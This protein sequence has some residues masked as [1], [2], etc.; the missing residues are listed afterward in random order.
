MICSFAPISVS[1]EQSVLITSP[2]EGAMITSDTEKF[3]ANIVGDCIKAIYYLDDTEIGIADGSGE[4]EI[5]EGI[6]TLGNHTLELIV[7]YDDGNTKSHTVQFEVVRRVFKEFYESFDAFDGTTSQT[8]DLRVTSQSK[9]S[10]IKETGKES[11]EGDVALKLEYKTGAVSTTSLP[12]LQSATLKNYGSGITT[13]EFDIKLNNLDE[14]IGLTDM[15]LWSSVTKLFDNGKIPGTD[16]KYL[17]GWLNIKIVFDYT[18]STASL[19]C[20][21][22]EIISDKPLV[23][24]KSLKSS[25][26]RMSLFQTKERAEGQP[27]AGMTVDNFKYSRD[28]IYTGIDSVT[29][30]KNDTE[31]EL[32]RNTLPLDAEKIKVYFNDELLSKSITDEVIELVVGSN[33]IPLSNVIYNDVEKSI[34][35]DINEKYAGESVAV[36]RILPEAKFKDGTVFGT[37]AE[38]RLETER[39]AVKGATFKVNGSPL[40]SVYQLS[41]GDI[42]SA[43]VDILNNTG[44]EKTFTVVLQTRYENSL[45]QIV[46]KS[47][48]LPSKV[49][50]QSVP[51]SLTPLR[52]AENVYVKLF[53]CDTVASA[54]PCGSSFIIP[55]SSGNAEAGF[56]RE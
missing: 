35:A 45:S 56:H 24:N 55:I 9:A 42:I 26:F 46:A 22:E 1:A 13:V 31:S 30:I 14:T 54:I 49:D 33:K 25:V 39:G 47:V 34:T 2:A 5:P 17:G 12:Y 27:N 8:V 6:L 36:V 23:Y 52:D 51:I 7:I 16:Y 15:C 19:Y 40:K 38:Y 41:T 4:L 20:D 3:T 48:T 10:M 29:C 11:Y 32:Y 44:A 53:V 37:A 43:D 21:G 18:N 50:V 28:L